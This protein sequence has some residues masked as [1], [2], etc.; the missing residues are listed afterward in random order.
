[1]LP[2]VVFAVGTSTNNYR[3]VSRFMSWR[4]RTTRFYDACKNRT[5]RFT[6]SLL[7]LQLADASGNP[8][9]LSLS[10][11]PAPQRGD[12][13]V[14]VQLLAHDQVGGVDVVHLLA[15]ALQAVLEPQHSLPQVALR[16]AVQLV[17]GLAFGLRHDLGVAINVGDLLDFDLQSFMRKRGENQ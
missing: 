3:S 7:A 1:M 16:H 9:E 17:D 8:L 13:Q 5:R 10:L 2:M 11:L 12:D 6:N 4:L 15:D 14:A